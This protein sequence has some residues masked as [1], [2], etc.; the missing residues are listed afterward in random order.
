MSASAPDAAARHYDRLDRFYRQLWGEHV[1]HGL[2]LDPGA[3][4]TQ[5]VR[6]LVHEVARDAH[7][8]D[9]DR[10]VDIGC[11][12][13][14][15][16]RLWAEAYGAHVTGFTVSEAQYAYA[17]RRTP[18]GDEPVP[19]VRLRDIL[20]NS[21]PAGDAD[22]VMAVES[23]THIDPP[24]SA[25]EEAARLLRPGGRLVACVWMAAPQAP[26]WARRHLLDPIVEEGR[27]AGLPTPTALSNTVTAAGLCVERVDDWT[28]QVRH[29]WTV[30]L[31]RL[32][33]ALLTDAAARRLLFNPTESE[34]VF[35]RTVPRIWCAQHLGML[36][37]GR[38]V[39]RKPRG[40]SG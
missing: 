16:A 4:P 22:A 37:Y 27:L 20:D 19:D 26:G 29:T 38:V 28:A 6:R 23:L 14:A 17:R 1:H 40:E 31:R 12:Y 18:D 30:V 10:V 35:A 13:G 11:G 25:L 39:A 2:W 9:G 3:S 7:L 21:L 15:P 36:R 5:A 8:S 24:A 33:W 32:V 34:R